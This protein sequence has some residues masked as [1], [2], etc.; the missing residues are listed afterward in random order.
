MATTAYE[1]IITRAIEVVADNAGRRYAAGATRREA[2]EAAIAEFSERW[3]QIGAAVAAEL[4]EV[5]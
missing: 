3:P 4:A 2:V 1:R 5:R